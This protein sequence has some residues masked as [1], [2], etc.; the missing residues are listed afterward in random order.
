MPFC[1]SMWSSPSEIP[2]WWPKGLIQPQM[3]FVC[4]QY[5]FFD[6]VL[7]ASI[8]NK[9]AKWC[10]ISI[11]GRVTKTRF[12]LLPKTIISN[13][14]KQKRQKYEKKFSRNQ[15]SGNEGQWSL[16]RWKT[17]KVSPTIAPTYCLEKVSRLQQRQMKTLTEL[18]IEE[19]K[20]IKVVTIHR[21]EY[22]KRESCTE[23]EPRI[24][25]EGPH[26]VFSRI[27]I[28]RGLWK[29]HLGP[30]IR[31]ESTL[32]SHKARNTAYF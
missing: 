17:N 19:T 30:R 12:N 18:R 1:L 31:G 15:T 32:Y 21:T 6:F 26:W 20:L 7:C 3:F 11:Q 28:S 8:F 23:K 22:Q 16:E 24:P 14:T 4:L 9:W 25:G 10:S 29:D 2:N 27:L 13:K 5:L